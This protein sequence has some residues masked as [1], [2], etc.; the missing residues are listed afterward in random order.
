[1]S[2]LKRLIEDWTWPK[3]FLFH[4]LSWHLQIFY[5]RG[6]LESRGPPSLRIPSRVNKLSN[7]IIYG[8]HSLKPERFRPGII[9]RGSIK[10]ERFF[11]R[12]NGSKMR[13]R[14]R[15][16]KQPPTSISHTPI[17]TFLD[18]SITNPLII[19]SKRMTR[20][21][22]IYEIILSVIRW[23]LVSILLSLTIHLVITIWP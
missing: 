15:R 1:M 6:K 8:P 9:V 11:I 5:F 7:T 18:I 14:S 4:S 3:R 23:L 2:S 17:K 19:P 13:H 20:E 22:K 12:G 21:T 16:K 10:K